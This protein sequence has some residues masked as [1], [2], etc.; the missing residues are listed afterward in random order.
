MIADLF[1]EEGDNLTAQGQ[2]ATGRVSYLRAL[3]SYLESGL[4]ET[5][6]PA[7]LAA[8]LQPELVTFYER[9]EQALARLSS[10]VLKKQRRQEK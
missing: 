1:K 7:G 8:E 9:K 3:I 5:P 4:S 6:L 10:E 2:A